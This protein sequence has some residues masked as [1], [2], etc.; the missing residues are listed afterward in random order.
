MFLNN[1]SHYFP[2]SIKQQ[3]DILIA[4]KKCQVYLENDREIR[5]LNFD[6][7]TKEYKTQITKRLRADSLDIVGRCECDTF[8]RSNACSHLWALLLKTQTN[9]FFKNITAQKVEWIFDFIDQTSSPA[10]LEL[11]KEKNQKLRELELILKREKRLQHQPSLSE[12]PETHIEKKFGPL[13]FGLDF[14]APGSSPLRAELAVFCYEENTKK[15]GPQHFKPLSLTEESCRHFSLYS[16]R[17]TAT[18]LRNFIPT[19]LSPYWRQRLQRHKRS[20]AFIPKEAFRF[21]LERLSKTNKLFLIDSKIELG[22]LKKVRYCPHEKAEIKI[23]FIETENNALIVEANLLYQNKSYPLDKYHLNLDLNLA[24]IEDKVMHLIPHQLS[25]VVDYLLQEKQLV[26]SEDDVP[27]LKELVMDYLPLESLEHTDLIGLET[28]ILAGQLHI[29]LNFEWL[30]EGPLII[31]SIGVLYPHSKVPWKLGDAQ[32]W[33]QTTRGPSRWLRNR[34][35][36]SDWIQQCSEINGVQI[37]D[38][39]SPDQIMINPA[40]FFDVCSSLET[41]GAVLTSQKARLVTPKNYSNTLRPNHDWFELKAEVKFQVTE[42]NQEVT[43][44]TYH[45]PEIL[46]RSVER[47]QI[48]GPFL[49]LGDGKIGLLPEVWLKKQLALAQLAQEKDDSL[50]VHNSQ[51]L[52]LE[53]LLEKERDQLKHISWGELKERAA[54]TKLQETEPPTSFKATLR[55][56]QKTGLHWLMFIKQMGMGGCLADEMGLGK[57][58]Q[59]LSFFETLR[60]ESLKKSQAEPIHL[61]IVPKS[62]L[63]NWVD[64]ARRFAPSL[65][66]MPLNQNPEE[67]KKFLH[68]L[69]EQEKGGVILCSY[70]IMRQ[71]A[72]FLKDFH[73]DT[74]VLDEAQAI[75]NPDSQTAKMACLLK[76]HSRFAMS[77]TPVENSLFDLFSLFRF[78][79]PHL[80]HKRLQ[81]NHFDFANPPLMKKILL[82]MSPFI[83]RRKKSDV[84]TELPEKIEAVQYCEMEPEQE[85]VY[86]ELKKYYQSQIQDKT[87]TNRMK[88]L[89]ALLRLRQAAADPG[90]I[91]PF[92]EGRSGKIEILIKHLLEIQANGHK[93]LVFSQFTSLLKRIETRLQKEGIDYCYLDGQTQNREKVV[94]EFKTRSNKTVFLLSLKAGGVGLNLTEASYAFILD[95]WW[96]PAIE[97]QAFDRIHR[98]GQTSSVFTYRMISRNTVEEKVLAL[99][100]DK[101]LLA[102]EL[103]TSD[104]VSPQDAVELLQFLMN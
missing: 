60:F 14:S 58:L 89:E 99:Q 46:H 88:A 19:T 55:P 34:Q 69:F 97:A 41:M 103:L 73:F 64:E 66:V 98:I 57:T 2:D 12:K 80:T 65:E 96:N 36:E 102:D 56:Y 81:R 6:S 61:V 31:G 37:L 15:I 78:L 28:E 85:K 67:R 82:S 71:E 50:M 7:L 93:A 20:V 44:H 13:W 39:E 1:F 9:E 38:P 84:L 23:Q 25:T 17:E 30:A 22:L 94:H 48:P 75:K 87:N 3:A 40:H 53:L 35:L 29:N 52:G 95:P 92:Y 62:L 68:D 11:K 18:L 74:I 5:S 16:E 90:L 32:S 70:G 24:A 104:Q 21:T 79:W 49:N 8:L 42:E 43:E 27:Q 72:M 86:N 100:K 77:G 63:F 26:I 33:N 54:E 4:Q 10:V 91:D 101:R 47:G 45:M 83:L 76:A 59:V 51:A